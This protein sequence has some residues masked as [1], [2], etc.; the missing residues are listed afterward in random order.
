MNIYGIGEIVFDIVF[1][2]GQPQAGVPGGSTFNA[3]VSLGRRLPDTRV[4]MVSQMGDDTV[5]DI[6]SRFMIDNGVNP[7]YVS[8]PEKTQTTL[9]VAVLDENND[10]KYEFFRDRNM[11]AFQT[12]DIRFEE[13]DLLVFGSF[14]AISPATG[15]AC[16]ALVEKAKEAG[17]MVYYDINFRKNH[18]SQLEECR[19][20]I[21]SNIALSD[22][23]RGSDEDIEA[24]FG[25]SDPAAV[26][27]KVISPLCKNF[28]CTRGAEST[29]V[30]SEKFRGEYPVPPVE[31]IVSTIGAGDN[32]NAGFNYAL[33]SCGIS[34][35]ESLAQEDWD[36]LTSAGHS[37][38]AEVCRSI[39]NYVEA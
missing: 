37:F 3:I 23:V 24:V 20:G 7:D 25:D 27:E 6:I 4:N 26:Y 35:K 9:S 22:V 34:S 14:F 17:A 29:L 28:I 19:E 15:G 1:R 21:L 36:K 38:A 11:P 13:G 39:F 33:M 32:F 2:D 10:A 30:F 8:R 18:Y 31:D 12:P 16:R 5:G